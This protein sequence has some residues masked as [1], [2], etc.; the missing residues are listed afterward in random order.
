[1]PLPPQNYL[2]W[3]G[4]HSPLR[5]ALSQGRLTT[6]RLL[7]CITALHTAAISATV[8]RI[9]I[10]W[11]Y[12]KLWWDDYVAAAITLV[13]VPFALMFLLTFG[14]HGATLAYSR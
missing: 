2:A 1:M 9:R 13:D 6:R 5:I 3:K 8:L 4:E 11:K 14:T 10:R 12:A 7:V